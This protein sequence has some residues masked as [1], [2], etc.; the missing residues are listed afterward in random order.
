MKAEY[1]Y[2]TVFII[3]FAIILIF[4]EKNIGDFYTTIAYLL[5]A[6]VSA[7]RVRTFL[8]KFDIWQLAKKRNGI[9]CGNGQD[10]TV[11][12]VLLMCHHGLAGS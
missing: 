2:L 5:F 8:R 1:K 10:D 6:S 3:I 11:L 7:K 12:F 9:F 4:I